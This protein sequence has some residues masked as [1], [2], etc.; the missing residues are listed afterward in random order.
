M[1]TRIGLLFAFASL[2][3][4]GCAGGVVGDNNINASCTGNCPNFSVNGLGSK[5]PTGV[6]TDVYTDTGSMKKPTTNTSSVRQ[7]ITTVAPLPA[8]AGIVPG[9]GHSYVYSA[10][11]RKHTKA[12]IA[13][14]IRSNNRK[15]LRVPAD[16]IMAQVADRLGRGNWESRAAFAD[17]ILSDAVTTKA[18][19]SGEL[20]KVTLSR[21]NGARNPND[22]V[23]D[24]T[25]TRETCDPGEFF[26]VH[27]GKAFL[28]STCLN[29]VFDRVVFT[30]SP[31]KKT[32]SIT[33]ASVDAR[34]GC[35]KAPYHY[36]AM[37]IR[38]SNYKAIKVCVFDVSD[39]LSQRLRWEGTS[40][41]DQEGSQGRNVNNRRDLYERGHLL[42]G[43]RL[44]VLRLKRF[45]HD[46][47][48]PF[49]VGGQAVNVPAGR[50]TYYDFY[51]PI[52]NGEGVLRMP[53]ES[54]QDHNWYVA[55]GDS[56]DLKLVH[57]DPRR[58][59]GYMT[60]K[61][62]YTASCG[63]ADSGTY[64]EMWRRFVCKDDNKTRLMTTGL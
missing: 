9:D 41:R 25:W 13:E 6:T 12:E 60:R 2:V 52:R 38:T 62:G 51:L 4:A 3:L 56:R 44:M 7:E 47:K 24:F 64:S 36:G 11:R 37:D 20:S 50:Y 30:A 21:V 18:C 29:V 49:Y 1:I 58:L 43:E 27:G 15:I 32:S 19:T 8:S 55:F 45:S 22:Q 57:N 10:E 31:P 34:H 14:A 54:I 53:E 5:T 23:Y 59:E 16:V 61:S 35:P 42:S 26:L 33:T 28:S 17:W 48:R 40:N 63:R 39:S 46:G